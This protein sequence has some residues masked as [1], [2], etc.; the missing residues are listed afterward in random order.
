MAANESLE[1]WTQIANRPG[2]YSRAQKS[3]AEAGEKPQ[4]VSPVVLALRSKMRGLIAEANA[5]KRA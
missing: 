3:A 4:Q 1:K 5:R 2:L